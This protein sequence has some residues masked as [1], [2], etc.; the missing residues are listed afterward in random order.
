MP[1]TVYGFDQRELP[2]KW[3]TDVGAQVVPHQPTSTALGDRG[4]TERKAL[5]ALLVSQLESSDTA[6]RQKIAQPL[7]W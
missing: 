3:P 6:T 7:Q 1:C 4:D 2:K 5:S